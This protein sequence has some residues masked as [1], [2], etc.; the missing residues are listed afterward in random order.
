[1]SNYNK[2]EQYP[3]IKLNNP[4]NWNIQGTSI[5]GERTG[6]L[7]NPLKIILDGGVYSSVKPIAVFLTHSHCDHTLGLPTLFG[8]RMNKIKG[9]ENLI[10]RPLYL[11]KL[12]EFPVQ[13]LMESAIYLSDNDP[14]F[15]SDIN[16]NIKENV[17]KRQG[18]QPIISKPGDKFRI[19]GLRNIE[20]EVLKA[21][22]DTESLGY[23]FNSIKNKL[24][25]EFFYTDDSFKINAKKNGID[26]TEE[27]IT[28]EFVFFC[29]SSINNLKFHNEW[30]KF[31]I[32]IC[33][34]TSFPEM[35]KNHDT[36]HTCFDDLETIIRSNPEKEWFIIHTSPATRKET[37]INHQNRL[38]KDGIKIT[39]IR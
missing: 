39:F 32:I 27:F 9:Q 26:I 31:P 15:A 18:Y 16:Y 23:G 28:P 36:N 4:S 19:P 34:S 3:N 1:M 13:K 37:L 2:L 11:P 24:K 10:G 14:N 8:P 33:E 17:W 12:A 29:D 30:K 6:F 25:P 21:Y 20:V 35:K 38:S 5:A 22:H 7:L